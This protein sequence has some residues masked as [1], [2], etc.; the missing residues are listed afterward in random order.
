MKL[1][2]PFLICTTAVLSSLIASANAAAVRLDADAREISR[3]LLHVREE[4]P[5]K[6]GRLAL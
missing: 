3:K 5:V 6:P 2:R 1:M 4:L